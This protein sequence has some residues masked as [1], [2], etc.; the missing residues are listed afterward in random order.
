M[1]KTEVIVTWY[2]IIPKDTQILILMFFKRVIAWS[3]RFIAWVI[4]LSNRS[5]RPSVWATLNQVIEYQSEMTSWFTAW[6]FEYNE[7]ESLILTYCII[8]HGFQSNYN[9]GNETSSLRNY[10]QECHTEVARQIS[11]WPAPEYPSYRACWR[12]WSSRRAL[13]ENWYLM[14]SSRQRC[15]NNE[16]KVSF[17]RSYFLEKWPPTSHPNNLIMET[18]A[19]ELQQLQRTLYRLFVL[20]YAFDEC[21]QPT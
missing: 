17:A 20:Q 16:F 3:H 15:S 18:S 14:T 1:K 12:A 4:V 8:G 9:W 19:A 13:P 21:M 10:N 11:A 7:G 5:T 2:G 6:D